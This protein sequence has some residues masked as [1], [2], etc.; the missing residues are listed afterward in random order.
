MRRIWLLVVFLIAGMLSGF[1]CSHQV[2]YSKG[3]SEVIKQLEERLNHP[4]MPLTHPVTFLHAR[5]H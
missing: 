3:K 4:S 1:V 2:G 5:I